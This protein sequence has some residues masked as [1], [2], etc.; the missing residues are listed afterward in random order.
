MLLVVKPLAACQQY[1]DLIVSWYDDAWGH[2][3]PNKPDHSRLLYKGQLN[4]MSIP[5]AYVVFQ[6]ELPI[7][8]FSLVPNTFEVGNPNITMLNNIYV[9][10]NKRGLGVGKEIVKIAENIANKNFGIQILQIGT[11][12][13]SLVK[14]YENLVWSFTGK[15]ILE[16]KHIVYMLQKNI[17]TTQDH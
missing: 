7:G 8:I 9:L 2:L 15:E 12:E 10:S 16:D 17:S 11:T 5:I 6:D 3:R 14:F 13:F 4:T 1:T